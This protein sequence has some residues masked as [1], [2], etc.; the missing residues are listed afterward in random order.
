MFLAGIGVGINFKDYD[1]IK[2]NVS[3][4]N[5]PKPIQSF[6][7]AGLRSL[8]IDNLKYFKYSSPTPVQK[9]AIPIIREGRDLMATAQTGSGK[10][11]SKYSK[12]NFSFVLFSTLK[13]LILRPPSCY[14][15]ST[16]Y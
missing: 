15:S 14:Q 7:Q 4:E 1:S 6:E 16:D 5:A 13:C 12:S 3:G 11:V 8:I 10:T 2:I 9:Y